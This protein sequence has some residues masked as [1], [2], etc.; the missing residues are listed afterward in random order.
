MTHLV[1]VIGLILGLRFL[2]IKKK[3][4]PSSHKKKTR[5]LR[6]TFL[7]GG[8]QMGTSHIG[9]SIWTFRNA[10]FP[11]FALKHLLT[12]KLAGTNTK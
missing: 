6:T 10:D 2:V 12:L 8:V 4:Y 11:K 1:G 9:T 3:D 7:Y 5:P